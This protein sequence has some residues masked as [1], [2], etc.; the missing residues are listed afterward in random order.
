MEDE[1]DTKVIAEERYREQMALPVYFMLT[2]EEHSHMKA[3]DE[4][5]VVVDNPSTET[6]HWLHK[7]LCVGCAKLGTVENV[8]PTLLAFI[9]ETRSEEKALSRIERYTESSSSLKV[10]V[11][12]RVDAAQEFVMNGLSSAPDI[13]NIAKASA[14]IDEEYSQDKNTAVIKEELEG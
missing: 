5:Y 10:A 3:G 14:S 1:L 12:V 2:T 4:Y 6:Q 9:T 11:M 13:D 8:P 7:A